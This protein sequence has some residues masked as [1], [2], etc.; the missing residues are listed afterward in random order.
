MAL[1]SDMPPRISSAGKPWFSIDQQIKI[2]EKRGLPLD[3]DEQ[4][5]RLEEFL[6]TQNYYRFSGYFKQFMEPDG[7]ER[8]CEG[9]TL[10]QLLAVYQMDQQ[11]RLLI[12]Q[13]VQ[14]LEPVIRTRLAYRFA[15]GGVEGPTA[16]L[17]KRAYEP[18]RP[19]NNPPKGMGAS[20]WE[21]KHAGLVRTRD[22]LLRSIEDTL[23]REEL[24][25]R[26]F[27]EKG[28]E[29]PLWAMVESLSL[30]DVSKMVST[31]KNTNQVEKLMDD[32]GFRSA[33]ELRRAVGNV[34]FF[35]N[36]SAHHNRLWGR[37]LTRTVARSPWAGGTPFPYAGVSRE[38]PLHILRLLADW[39]DYVQGNKAYSEQLWAMVG[40]ETVYEEGMK[41]PRL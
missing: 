25:L 39:V 17:Q 10:D 21:D 2:L 26:H 19:S 15:D 18:S 41:V 1:P 6:K 5:Q 22:S 7:A 31:W 3:T 4:K 28:Q 27:Q 32:L 29:V 12:F 30:G 20:E 36:L 40:K 8:F 11:V 34:N 13:G 14:V 35:R 24:Y 16:Y 33:A 37:R 23:G 9:T 38:S